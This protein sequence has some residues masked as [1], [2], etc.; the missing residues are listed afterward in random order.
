MMRLYHVVL[1]IKV[2]QIL[3]NIKD[4]NYKELD[5]KLIENFISNL[6]N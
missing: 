4:Q 1:W 3:K 5:D 2:L 6:E